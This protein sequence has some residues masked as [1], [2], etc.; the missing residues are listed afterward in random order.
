MALT[1]EVCTSCVSFVVEL[2]QLVV[3]LWPGDGIVSY[4]RDTLFCEVI[5]FF[6]ELLSKTGAFHAIAR[7]RQKDWKFI[8][9]PRVG[10]QIYGEQ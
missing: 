2:E 10:N 5:F 4:W 8:S 1:D 9:V 7:S 6:A 3:S